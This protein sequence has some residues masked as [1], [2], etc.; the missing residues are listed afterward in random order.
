MR[1]PTT[2]IALERQEAPGPSQGPRA[3]GPSTPLG[4]H[5]GPG[6]LARIGRSQGRSGE[7][8]NLPGASRRSNPSFRGEGKTCPAER[9]RDTGQPRA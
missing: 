4:A 7:L 6:I 8:R 2:G 5:L 3:P 9:G 1:C